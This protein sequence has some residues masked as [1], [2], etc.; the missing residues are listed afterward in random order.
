MAAAAATIASVPAAAQAQI[1]I[2]VAGGPVTPA[3]AL[4][5]VVQKGFHGGVVLELGVPVLPLGIRAD[6]MY[7][8]LPGV[9]DGRNLNDVFGTLN[10]SLSLLPIPVLS[11]YA[12]AGVGIYSSSFAVDAPTTTGR[13]TDYGLNAGVGG[14]IDLIVIRPFVEVRYHRVLS[15]PNRDFV[16][17]TVGIFF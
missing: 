5:D 3:G 9:G 2:G 6:V 8:R 10:G 15:E 1:S 16:P 11:A 14:S 7:M 13:T 4:S 17:I 12:S